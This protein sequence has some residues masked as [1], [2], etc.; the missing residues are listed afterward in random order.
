MALIYLC[1]GAGESG[2]STIV[3]QMRYGYRILTS[4]LT[5]DWVQLT[6]I[7]VCLLFWWS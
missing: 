5:T 1:L 6:F 3:K 4:S 7:F 2:K